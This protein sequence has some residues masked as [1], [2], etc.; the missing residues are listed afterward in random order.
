MLLP[1]VVMLIMQPAGI[2]AI[3]FEKD[4]INVRKYQDRNCFN[5]FFHAGLR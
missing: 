4:D 3:A 5:R 2:V 1:V